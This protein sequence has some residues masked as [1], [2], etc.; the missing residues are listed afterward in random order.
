MP[1]ETQEDVSTHFTDDLFP[2]FSFCP[3]L[4]PPEAVGGCSAA[5]SSPGA[6][7]EGTCQSL[8]PR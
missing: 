4:G 5:V 1:K 2:C 6:G 3:F 7:G 8:V